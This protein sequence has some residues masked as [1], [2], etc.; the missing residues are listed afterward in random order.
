MP[1]HL[2]AVAA[3]AVGYA[4]AQEC[5]EPN[6]AHSQDLEVDRAFLDEEKKEDLSPRSPKLE[7][8]FKPLSERSVHFPGHEESAL[9]SAPNPIS[10]RSMHSSQRLSASQHRTMDIKLSVSAQKIFQSMLLPLLHCILTELLHLPTV[11]SI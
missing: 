8:P 9:S 2:A 3:V 5:E 10:I 11:S 4:S 7:Q 6:Q 1:A